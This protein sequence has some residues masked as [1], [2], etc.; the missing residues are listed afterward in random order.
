MQRLSKKEPSLYLIIVK[1][2]PDALVIGLYYIKKRFIFRKCPEFRKDIRAVFRKILSKDIKP[3]LLGLSRLLKVLNKAFYL[4]SLFHKLS[5]PA[6]D[7][8]G[9]VSSVV[10]EIILLKRSVPRCLYRKHAC[11]ACLI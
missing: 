7:L 9:N 1:C 10:R 6:Y 4:L 5:H 2:D 8:Y 3:D 11:F